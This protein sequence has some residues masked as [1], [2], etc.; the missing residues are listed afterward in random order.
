MQDMS[1]S[2]E[3]LPVQTADSQQVVFEEGREEE[4]LAR[5]EGDTKL[6]GWFKL[7][8]ED[9]RFRNV[10]YADIISTHSWDKNRKRWKRL[11]RN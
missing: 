7:N 4:A 9:L 2:V 8:K 3:R 1:H 11:R 6:T 5:A 10:L